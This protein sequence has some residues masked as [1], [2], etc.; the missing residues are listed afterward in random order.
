MSLVRFRLW[1]FFITQNRIHNFFAMQNPTEFPVSYRIGKVKNSASHPRK[2]PDGYGTEFFHRMTAQESFSFLQIFDDFPCLIIK[3]S[4]LE[5][6]LFI[7]FCNLF[8]HTAR[9]S[10]SNAPVRNIFCHDASCSD[11][12]ITSDM[13]PRH[14]NRVSA[15]PYIITDRYLNPIFIS[16]ISC[17]RMN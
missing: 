11:N 5:I 1:A 8:Y 14:N 10:H 13:Y 6:I 7:F 16:R 17:C 9:I 4:V 15:K 12:H 3:F 2:F